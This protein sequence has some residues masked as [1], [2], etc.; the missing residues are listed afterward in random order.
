MLGWFV[1]QVYIPAAVSMVG[2]CLFF[3]PTTQRKS[4]DR[5]KLHFL[6]SHFESVWTWAHLHLTGLIPTASYSLARVGRLPPPPPFLE[7]FP[8]TPPSACPMSLHPW[9]FFEFFL[10]IA[11][12]LYFWHPLSVYPLSLLC[13]KK[14]STLEFESDIKMLFINPLN[15][16]W[17]LLVKLNVKLI[18]AHCK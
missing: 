13:T 5:V 11:W 8:F 3:T 4:S 10:F 7:S 16:A 12:Q 1:G 14:Q 6:L 18:N 15:M 9:I 2:V 17:K